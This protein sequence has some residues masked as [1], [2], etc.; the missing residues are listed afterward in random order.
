MAAPPPQGDNEPPPPPESPAYRH[1]GGAGAGSGTAGEEG[2]ALHEWVEQE[3]QLQRAG[4]WK[5]RA[6][7]A[8]AA[9]RDHKARLSR[10]NEDRRAAESVADVTK[11]RDHLVARVKTLERDLGTV[12]KAAGSPA[13]PPAQ[14]REGAEGAEPPPPPPRVRGRGGGNAAGI[15]YLLART[16]PTAPLTGA[17]L[18]GGGGGA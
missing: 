2:G 15:R 4:A 9:T 10:A 3:Q 12:R 17:L 14:T 6:I 1:R 16:A 11:E 8:V 7:S 5:A 18:Q 13:K